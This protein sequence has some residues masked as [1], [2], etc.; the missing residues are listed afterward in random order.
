MIMMQNMFDI[1]KS[2]P[3]QM[4]KSAIHIANTQHET[5]LNKLN[6]MLNGS[7]PEGFETLVEQYRLF[8]EVNECPKSAFTA[9]LSFLSE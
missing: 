5:Q 8:L 2:T 3:T 1:E 7:N 6:A 9:F 4:V